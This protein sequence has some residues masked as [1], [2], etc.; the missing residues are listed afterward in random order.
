M[1]CCGWEDG[2]PSVTIELVPK[3]D[4]NNL[5]CKKDLKKSNQEVD[6]DDEVAYAEDDE[7]GGSG[8]TVHERL[9]SST[10]IF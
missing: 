2:E 9:Y 7:D 3:C 8:K 1:I 6:P 10:C 5:K 4:P